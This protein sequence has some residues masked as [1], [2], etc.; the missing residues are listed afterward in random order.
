M[1]EGQSGSG[2]ERRGMC[3][4]RLRGC[5]LPYDHSFSDKCRVSI[6]RVSREAC[7]I[8]PHVPSWGSKTRSFSCRYDHTLHFL[9]TYSH[10]T[11]QA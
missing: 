11:L 10:A 1:K 5:A 8:E 3:Y 7:G 9:H 6:E 2:G 4:L